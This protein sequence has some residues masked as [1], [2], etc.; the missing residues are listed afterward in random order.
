MP[1]RI[2]ERDKRSGVTYAWSDD[3]FELPVIDITH[4]AFAVRTGPEE[5]TSL[6]EDFL[7]RAEGRAKLPA[8]LRRFMFRLLRRR[9]FLIRG[10]SDARGTFVSGMHT[11][12]MKLG[13]ENLGAGYASPLDRKVAASL[14]ALSAR[15]R[16][17][18]VVDLMVEALVPALTARAGRPLHLLNIGGGP[19]IDSLNALIVIRTRHPERVVDRRIRVHVLDR[20]EAGPN[21][22]AR[23]LEAL[24]GEGAPLHGLDVGL[25]FVRYDWAEV[26]GLREVIGAL[27]AVEGVAV[28]S[29]EGGLFEYASDE[30]IIANLEALRVGLPDDFAMVGTVTRDDRITRSLLRTSGIPIRPRGLERFSALASRAGWVVDRA[31]EGPTSHNLRLRRAGVPPR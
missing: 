22:G 23:A 27:N 2:A 8:F 17:R 13:P 5:L 7:R 9:S 21:F 3:G 18:D 6:T 11:Y 16:L 15:L 4:P 30:E 28:G 29:T 25:D 10:L 20:D 26:G 1:T 19:A 12:L 14:P 31:I 24:R